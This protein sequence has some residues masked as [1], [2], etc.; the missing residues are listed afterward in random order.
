MGRF[1]LYKAKMSLKKEL[2]HWPE[3]IQSEISKDYFVS[4]Q[5]FL[6]KEK[7]DGNLVFPKKKDIFRAF[8]VTPYDE[9]KLVILGQD[10]YH[11]A[12]Q[13]HG[14]S[15]SVPKG[16]KRPPSLM[17]IYK[18]LDAV[19]ARPH[20]DLIDWA[21]QGVFLLNSVLTVRDGQAASHRN[22]GWEVF[23]DEVLKSLN[24]RTQPV[25]YLLWGAYAQKKAVFLDNQNHLVLQAP[26]PS[27]LSAYRGFLGCGHFEKANQFLEAKG[28]LPIK[29]V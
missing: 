7:S 2:K 22:K 3:K 16:V 29:W 21:E 19:D 15:F 4:L 1:F 28:L 12:G 11:G 8:Q 27:P 10:P 9:V 14:L 26:H 18:E 24:A 23:T 5:S 6:K 13:A 17:N 20:G 25:V